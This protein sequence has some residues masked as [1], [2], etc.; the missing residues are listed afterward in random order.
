MLEEFVEQPV[1]GQHLGNVVPLCPNCH[2]LFDG[3]YGEV[4]EAEIRALCDETARRPEV[5]VHVIDFIRA[6]RSTVPTTRP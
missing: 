1:A 4:D 6:E 3:P 5:L 2:T